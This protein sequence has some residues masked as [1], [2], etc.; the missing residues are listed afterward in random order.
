MADDLQRW[1]KQS[2]YPMDDDY[3]FASEIMR[4]KQSYWPDNLMRRHILPVA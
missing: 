3:I 2:I 4:G 1:R